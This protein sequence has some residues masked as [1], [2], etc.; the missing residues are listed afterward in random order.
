MA[1]PTQSDKDLFNFYTTRRDNA[2]FP[3]SVVARFQSIT[4]ILSSS[5]LAIRKISN[6]RDR[7]LFEIRGQFAIDETNGGHVPIMLNPDKELPPGSLVQ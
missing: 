5:R 7:D 6:Y 3:Y 2:Y 1:T 4:N